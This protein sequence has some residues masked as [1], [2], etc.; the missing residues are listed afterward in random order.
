VIAL[1]LV[2]G[3]WPASLWADGG[4]AAVDGRGLP[5]RSGLAGGI[6]GHGLGDSRKCVDAAGRAPCLE[7]C[8]TSP[9]RSFARREFATTGFVSARIIDRLQRQAP[10]ARN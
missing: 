5:A 6:G 7:A 3:S 2:G 8:I 4:A 9:I 10:V 1:E